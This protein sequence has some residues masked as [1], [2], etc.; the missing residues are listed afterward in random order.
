MNGTD[1]AF[2]AVSGRDGHRGEDTGGHQ[3]VVGDD[4]AMNRILSLHYLKECIFFIS[5]IP[6]RNLDG[7][8]PAPRTLKPR[9]LPPSQSSN[10]RDSSLLRLQSAP[11]NAF[12][13]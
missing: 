3:V 7:T 6:F 11:G 5:R 9:F 8:A 12:P 2:D 1:V 10:I 4:V 13:V